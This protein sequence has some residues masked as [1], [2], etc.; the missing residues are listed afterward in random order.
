MIISFSIENFGSIK[1]KQ[2]L[3]FEA[4]KSTHLED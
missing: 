3:S 4:E 1:D 2:E